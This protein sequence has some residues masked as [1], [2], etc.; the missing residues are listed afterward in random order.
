MT[1]CASQ[2]LTQSLIE[3]A[4]D[5]QRYDQAFAATDTAYDL[6]NK[7]INLLIQWIHQNGGSLPER[8]KNA[9]ELMLLKPGQL[10]AIEAIV[11]GAFGMRSGQ[12]TKMVQQT[13]NSELVGGLV[14][15]PDASTSCGCLNSGACTRQT[16]WLLN[17]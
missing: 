10:Q 9:Q 16:I 5:L 17:N 2:A 1:S 13:T 7:T 15:P 14:P 12:S 3:E 4:T 6:P 11:G 8:R